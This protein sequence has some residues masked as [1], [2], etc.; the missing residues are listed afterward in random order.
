MNVSAA[1]IPPASTPW[2]LLTIWKPSIMFICH[3]PQIYP[4]SFHISKPSFRTQN[5]LRKT[6]YNKQKDGS[7][8]SYILKTG[9]PLATTAESANW[10]H[11]SAVDA[12]PAVLGIETQYSLRHIC[13]LSFTSFVW[14]SQTQSFPTNQ[15]PL[16]TH[17][18]YHSSIVS[19]YNK[20]LGPNP[21]SFHTLKVNYT[22]QLLAMH[23]LSYTRI[24]SF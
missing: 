20:R 10:Q 16:H 8:R 2:Q 6:V 5:K 15:K 18:L 22:T 12:V 7:F 21:S 14:H 4:L 24:H 13:I 1:Q 19:L 11:S 9:L 23:V 3:L 17:A